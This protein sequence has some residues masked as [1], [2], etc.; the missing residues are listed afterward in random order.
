MSTSIEEQKTV[1]ILEKI[2]PLGQ[3][4]IDQ[5]SSSQSK[6]DQDQK[7]KKKTKIAILRSGVILDADFKNNVRPLLQKGSS[8]IDIL[9]KL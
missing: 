9:A 1:N 3:S 2:R 5:Y 4:E 8:Y 6:T 7:T